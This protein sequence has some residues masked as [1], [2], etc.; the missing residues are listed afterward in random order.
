MMV[1]MTLTHPEKMKS[2]VSRKSYAKLSQ[3]LDVPNL[4]KVQLD[5]FHW[6]QEEGLRQLL[7]EVFPIKDFTGNRLEISIVGYEFRDP[8]HTE[9]E[10]R[11]Y[12]DEMARREAHCRSLGVGKEYRQ[13]V[14]ATRGELHARLRK[15]LPL[16]KRLPAAKEKPPTSPDSGEEE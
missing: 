11:Y 7:D 14:A 8:R 6:F 9:Q 10:C 1:S 16:P 2:H 5:S 3:I 15:A 13:L 4:I 12:R